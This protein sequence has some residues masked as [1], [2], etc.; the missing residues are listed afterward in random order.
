MIK[1]HEY[2][3]KTVRGMIIDLTKDEFRERNIEML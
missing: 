3:C 1:Q 2:R